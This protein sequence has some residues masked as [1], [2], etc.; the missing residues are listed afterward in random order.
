MI[1]SACRWD[2][3]E[4][5]Q[6]A[7]TLGGMIPGSTGTD[8][9]DVSLYLALPFLL[10]SLALFLFFPLLRDNIDFSDVGPP[11]TS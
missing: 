5:E 1:R 2:A 11:P 4:E 10:G 9:F 7:A 8:S 6:K 3:T